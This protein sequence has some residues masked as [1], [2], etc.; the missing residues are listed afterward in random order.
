M[1]I[2][3]QLETP[4]LLLRD[5][6]KSDWQR[7]HSYAS[8]PEVVR[9]LPFGPN[10]E[11]DTNHFLQRNIKLQRQQPRQHFNLAVTLKDDK[12]LIGACRISLTN[13]DKQE[14]SI[15]YCFAQ[16]FWG[17]GYATEAVRKLLDFGFQQ[18]N[19]HRIFATCY[20]KNVLSMRVLVK[21]GMRHEGYLQE[22]EWVKGE[23]RDSVLYA[24][25]DREWMQIQ[26][27]GID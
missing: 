5:F 22:Y 15:G 25:L 8:D 14:G 19:L 1:T 11:E 2:N 12:Q 26:I 16:Q 7:V 23:W 17:Q 27:R 10:S 24:V 13:P 6:I 20:P 18:L 9:Y 3:L 4:R 21:S